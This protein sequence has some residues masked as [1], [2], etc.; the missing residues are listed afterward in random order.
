MVF[1]SYQPSQK[2]CMC[3]IIGEIN[4]N[5][6][7]HTMHEMLHHGAWCPQTVP[8]Y[9]ISRTVG[10]LQK[11]ICFEPSDRKIEST[12]DD[13]TY[14]SCKISYIECQTKHAILRQHSSQQI[15]DWYPIS[16][17]FLVYIDAVCRL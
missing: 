10:I 8:I 7:L 2:V 4:L 12:G 3:E 11:Y 17:G 6:H 14:H 1:D 5:P 15:I 13:S 9:V 16:L